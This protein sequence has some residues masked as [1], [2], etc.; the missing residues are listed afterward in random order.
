[1]TA[2]QVVTELMREEDEQERDGVAQ[3]GED[4]T[5]R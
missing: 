4:E 2:G 1:M 3:T 5:P